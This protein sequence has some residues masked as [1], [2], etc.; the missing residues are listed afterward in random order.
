MPHPGAVTNRLTI[1]GFFVR[2]AFALLVVG[3]TYNPTRYAC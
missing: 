3:A 2:F 1:D